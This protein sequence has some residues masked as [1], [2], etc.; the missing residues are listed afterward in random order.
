MERKNVMKLGW[1]F[2]LFIT[3]SSWAVE[4]WAPL[5]P[6]KGKKEE[7]VGKESRS[8]E[9]EKAQKPALTQQINPTP[10]QFFSEEKEHLF[11]TQY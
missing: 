9:K 3:S 7:K 1:I 5:S 2:L 6:W 11:G 8:M 10:L 4:P